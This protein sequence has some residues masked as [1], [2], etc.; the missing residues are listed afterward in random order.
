MSISRLNLLGLQN[1]INNTH[2]LP[3]V[4]TII[5]SGR[6][7]PKKFSTVC[8]MNCTNNKIISKVHRH[9]RLFEKRYYFKPHTVDY[10]HQLSTVVY[11]HVSRGG[12]VVILMQI[13]NDGE[14]PVAYFSKHQHYKN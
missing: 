1:N 5:W 4:M 9:C 7:L 6:L 14:K 2:D 3:P 13:T 12:L 8:E 10:N 11:T